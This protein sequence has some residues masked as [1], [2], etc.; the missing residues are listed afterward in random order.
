MLGLIYL[1]LMLAW[2]GWVVYLAIEL[3]TKKPLVAL[4][5]VMACY[6]AGAIDSRRQ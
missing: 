6:V 2:G 5:I 4:L 1:G 3:V